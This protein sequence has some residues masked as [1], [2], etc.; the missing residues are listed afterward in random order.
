MCS[1]SPTKS[2][3][4]VRVLL[5][6]VWASAWLVGAAPG[7]D[8]WVLRLD[9]TGGCCAGIWAAAGGCCAAMRAAGSPEFLAPVFS[10]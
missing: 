8:W 2:R 6:I 3:F 7:Y 5:H 10:R 1:R 9:M 4:F